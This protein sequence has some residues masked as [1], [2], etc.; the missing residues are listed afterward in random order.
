MSQTL[1]PIITVPLL[2]HVTHLPLH[3][4]ATDYFEA[5]PR[6]HFISFIERFSMYFQR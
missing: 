4:Q 1:K 5:N 2:I 6:C 3:P